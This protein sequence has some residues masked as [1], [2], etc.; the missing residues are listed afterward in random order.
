MARFRDLYLSRRVAVQLPLGYAS[1]LPYLLIGETLITWLTTEGLSL[2]TVGAFTLCGLAYNFKLGWA[3]LLDGY[4]LPFLDRRRGW[5]LVFQIAVAFGIAALAGV[6]PKGP[7]LRTALVAAMLGFFAA[8][9]DIVVDAYRAD[10]LQGEDRAP[11]LSLFNVG[12]RLGML[13][14][15]GVALVLVK[16]LGWP[17]V[18]RA[19]AATMV[20]GVLA[21]LVAPSPTQKVSRPRSVVDAYVQPLSDLLGRKGARTIIAFVLLYRFGYLVAQPMNAPFLIKLGFSTAQLGYW[22]KGVGLIATLVGGLFAGPAVARLGTFR[23]MIVFGTTMAL[24]HLSW[25]G[26][27]Y[28]GPQPWMLV[29]TI[30]VEN[31]FIGLATTAFDAYLM[32]LT[33]ASYSGTQFGALAGLSSLGGR[34][35]GAT[36]GVLA[37]T[38][39][40]PLFFGLTS[41]SAVP[42]LILATRLPRE[43]AADEARGDARPDAPAA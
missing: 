26:L 41:L 42:S 30:C 1:G 21:T 39:G 40:W 8:S 22:R 28:T 29:I 19:L 6:D 14:A 9:Q 25:V 33:N 23:A 12:Y 38:L 16:P 2:K 13:A 35:F 32:Q 37:Q 34:L 7:P 10:V 20:V 18:Y 36:S 24:I 3:P 5:L 31:F 17:A 43:A 4:P 27:V 11:G 15:G